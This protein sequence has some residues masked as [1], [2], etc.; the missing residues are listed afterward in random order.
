MAEPLRHCIGIEHRM[1]DQD[2]HNWF[3]LSYASYLVLPR[4]LMQAM[5]ADWQHRFVELLEDMQATFRQ[6]NDNYTV[7]LRDEGGKYT[8]DPFRRYRHPDVRAIEIA[9]QRANHEVG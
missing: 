1:C 5:P 3:E 2:V 8:T 4:S 7:L 9:R 6:E